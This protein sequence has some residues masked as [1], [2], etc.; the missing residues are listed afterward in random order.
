M[1]KTLLKWAFGAPMHIDDPDWEDGPPEISEGFPDHVEFR[2]SPSTEQ[3]AIW[4]PRLRK[5]ILFHD[6]VVVREVH[7]DD[8]DRFLGNWTPYLAAENG[9]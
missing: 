6:V 5:W 8:T 9:E 4:N 7:R 3:L 2:I 1:I